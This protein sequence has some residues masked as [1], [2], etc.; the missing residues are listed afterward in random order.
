MNV[1]VSPQSRSRG[2]K[3]KGKVWIGNDNGRYVLSRLFISRTGGLH[4]SQQQQR[5]L[6]NGRVKGQLAHNCPHQ[7][8][9]RLHKYDVS[10]VNCMASAQG[11]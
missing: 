1:F 11:G 7:R 9:Q 4:S 8:H 3:V 6:V 10:A 5:R 2:Q